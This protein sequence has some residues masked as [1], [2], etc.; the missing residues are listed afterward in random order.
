MPWRQG[1]HEKN[2]PTIE[3]TGAGA[4]PVR[5]QLDLN[6]EL[7]QRDILNEAR[8]IRFVCLQQGVSNQ[9]VKTRSL[10]GMSRKITRNSPWAGSPSAYRS[11]IHAH[12]LLEYSGTPTTLKMTVALFP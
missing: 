5:S 2:V 4:Q 6:R 11:K 1:K 3:G 12:L 10:L 8:D 7:N 9:Y